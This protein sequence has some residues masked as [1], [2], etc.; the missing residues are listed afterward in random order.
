MREASG[1]TQRDVADALDWSLSKLIRIEKGPV[2]ISVTDV[3]ALLLQYRVTDD[4]RVD[5]LVEMARAA[6][7]PAWWHKYRDMYSS[8]F[9]TFLGLEAS[10]VRIRQSQSLVVPGLLQTE[11]Y[12]RGVIAASESDPDLVGRGVALR[13]ERQQLI[14]P[15]GPELFF[16]LDE[17]VLYRLI[18][19]AEVMRGQLH[20]LVEL[21]GKPSISIQVLPFTAGR[22]R[23]VASSFTIFELSEEYGDYSLLIEQPYEDTL[24]EE[25]SDQTKEY[26][27]IFRELEKIA[28]S[29]A[30]SVKL[31]EKVIGRTGGVS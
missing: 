31:I 25:P 10:S 11:G 23:G 27:A 14:G 8:Q 24:I 9:L 30:E 18:G 13:L 4:H 7:R 3:K 1:L 17:S 15:D 22:H 20:R 5:E 26:V 6:K 21:A 16:I 2:G 12:A 19:D 29:Q 28:L